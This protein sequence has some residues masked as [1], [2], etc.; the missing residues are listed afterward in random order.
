MM[1]PQGPKPLDAYLPFGVTNGS[2]SQLDVHRLTHGIW[3]DA[4]EAAAKEVG[5]LLIGET[6]P[7]IRVYVMDK[8]SALMV[9]EL[10]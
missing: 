1:D 4:M 3:N 9:E 2:L 6:D 7:R 5:R 10:T 8:I